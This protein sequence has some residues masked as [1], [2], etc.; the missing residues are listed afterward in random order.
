MD[1][2]STDH[3]QSL[4]FYKRRKT[5]MPPRLA[6]VFEG[7]TQTREATSIQVVQTGHSSPVVRTE[8]SP[9]HLT[10]P[11]FHFSVAETKIKLVNGGM[12]RNYQYL[13]SIQ[14]NPLSHPHDEDL[15]PDNDRFRNRFVID[16]DSYSQVANFCRVSVDRWKHGS[17]RKKDWKIN[18]FM[19]LLKRHNKL[20]S[21]WHDRKCISSLA[22]A[23]A[24]LE[25]HNLPVSTPARP[26]NIPK[27]ML[28]RY[29]RKRNTPALIS[30]LRLP[31]DSG[32]TSKPH[33]KYGRPYRPIPSR[34][35]KHNNQIEFKD[36]I[37]DCNS[38]QRSLGSTI[39]ETLDADTEDEGT[40][41]RDISGQSHV[42]LDLN[43]KNG[44]AEK[45]HQCASSALAIPYESHI[46][47][48]IGNRFVL[49]SFVRSEACYDVHT[50]EGFDS[51]MKYIAKVYSI[52][53]KKGK[54]RESRLRNLKRNV[55]KASCVASIDQNQRKW[56]FFPMSLDR[57][58]Q[59]DPSADP[60]AWHGRQQYQRHFPILSPCG[61]TSLTRPKPLLESYASVVQRVKVDLKDGLA[62]KK[63]R[64]RDRQR[65]KRQEKRAVKATNR[66]SLE[67]KEDT[68]EEQRK[69]LDNSPSSPK[70]NKETTSP[71]VMK[72]EKE[73]GSAQSN[74]EPTKGNRTLRQAH[75]VST[76]GPHD[77][78]GLSPAGLGHENGV[79]APP[80]KSE[81]DSL[82][83]EVHLWHRRP[84][85]KF[86]GFTRPGSYYVTELERYLQAFDRA[87]GYSRYHDT[88]EEIW[89]RLISGPA[90]SLKNRFFEILEERKLEQEERNL[91]HNLELKE[92]RMA[93]KEYR[94]ALEEC[95]MD[96]QSK[97]GMAVRIERSLVQFRHEKDLLLLSRFLHTARLIRGSTAYSESELAAFEHL[98][99]V[100][101][102]GGDVQSSKAMQLL[103]KGADQRVIPRTD[104]KTQGR[105]VVTCEAY[106]IL[107]L[108]S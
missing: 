23:K 95:R 12:S 107:R 22:V 84:Q 85:R 75:F 10:D 103:C 59:S 36:I 62:H 34:R 94:M 52:S 28:R 76:A 15:E 56:V 91:E 14:R 100:F 26:V 54:E 37:S 24:G 88:E 4:A 89:K 78:Y 67:D 64:A 73:R 101:F 108:L 63:Q 11:N 6:M 98:L 97:I 65:R 50:A 106:L 93:F 87:T 58:S 1:S 48:I 3:A 49:R 42:S 102:Y 29:R 38:F 92:Y 30:V 96:I 19:D 79:V 40:Y 90:V 46:G 66:A 33:C 35:G 71:Y 53:G 69:P 70:Y 47:A 5:E 9:S 25:T 80:S 45:T 68:S 16:G 57:N 31:R 21:E 27:N 41:V 61:I 8:P 32:R 39:L 2:T 86:P 18:P 99:H 105:N 44:M 82:W 83:Q 13:R 17:G 60:W 81:S 43:W 55:A 20:R 7:K 72:Q 104:P 51:D 77:S 74:Q